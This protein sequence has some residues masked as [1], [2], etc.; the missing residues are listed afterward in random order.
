MGIDI[1]NAGNEGTYSNFQTLNRGDY[2]N[3]HQSGLGLTR[4]FNTVGTLRSGVIGNN[5]LGSTT[6][7]VDHYQITGVDG[8]HNGVRSGSAFARK[9]LH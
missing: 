9:I 1:S 7:V 2:I 6:R 4:N 5:H 8:H 3:D